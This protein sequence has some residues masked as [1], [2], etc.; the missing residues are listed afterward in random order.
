MN[1]PKTSQEKLLKTSQV[2]IKPNKHLIPT[3]SCLNKFALKKVFDP[4][5]M[6]SEEERLL[7]EGLSCQM[8]KDGI[9]KIEIK[10]LMYIT[11]MLINNELGRY[12]KL[13]EDM[14]RH[15]IHWTTLLRDELK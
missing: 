10:E 3:I 11:D 5:G 6:T 13:K 8:K 15:G 9:Q 14:K 2:I 4:L 7:E 1:N 12:E